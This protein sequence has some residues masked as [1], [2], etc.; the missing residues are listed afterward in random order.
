MNFFFLSH[1]AEE[2]ARYHCDKHCVKMILEYAQL[3]YTAHAVNNAD[4][5]WRDRAPKNSY[6]KTH[7]FHP[8]AIWTRTTAGN[9][10]LLA[11]IAKALCQEFTHR[12]GKTHKTEAHINWLSE[13]LPDFPPPDGHDGRLPN[14]DFKTSRKPTFFSTTPVLP[15]C[16]PIP[17]AMAEECYMPDAVEA[18]RKFYVMVKHPIVTWVKRDVPSWFT[19]GVDLYPLLSPPPA[20]KKSK[21]TSI[22]QAQPRRRKRKAAAA[23]GEEGNAPASVKIEGGA[24]EDLVPQAKRLKLGGLKTD[25]VTGVAASDGSHSKA[26]A[27]KAMALSA[28]SSGGQKQVCSAKAAVHQSLSLS[29]RV[30][31][32]SRNVPVDDKT[33][34]GLPGYPH[35]L[36]SPMV[37]SCCA[38]RLQADPYQ[39]TPERRR[40]PRIAAISANV[41]SVK[42]EPV[43]RA[44][45]DIT[46]KVTV[47]LE[48]RT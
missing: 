33:T 19:E 28:A 47:K 41:V 29:P 46:P 7:Q 11:G 17:L 15:G 37:G 4:V 48:P 2:C 3:L 30:A 18:Y 20:K 16:T 39:P 42:T 36:K 44:A 31:S 8:T 43:T 10:R 13:N 23:S 32:S 27:R 21:K 5:A 40:S 1:I 24:G 26:G 45:A 12:Y 34:K 6:R 35:R 22:K 14:G 9:Y 38:I 25:P